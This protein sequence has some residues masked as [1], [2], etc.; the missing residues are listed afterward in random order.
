MEIVPLSTGCLGSC[1]YCKTKHARGK[2]GSYA[3]E[4]LVSRVTSVLEEG[5]VREI[6]LASE[7]T[8]AYG[9]DIGTNIAELFRKLT[10]VVE[11]KGNE[12]TMLRL[13][14]TNPPYI[15]DHLDQ[16][17]ETLRHPNVFNFLHIPVQSGSNTVLDRMKREYTVEQFRRVC[18]Y[19][20]KYAPGILIATDI[21]W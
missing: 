15:L 13:G 19:L 9:R 14:M 21:I 1:T 18:D 8:G 5:E 6:W 11:E 10:A 3:L 16:I 7:D 2:L 4:A 12:A 20:K 17:A